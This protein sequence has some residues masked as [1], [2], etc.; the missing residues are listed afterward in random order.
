MPVIKEY[1]GKDI[2]RVC[3]GEPY[4][5]GDEDERNRY[6]PRMRG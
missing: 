4:R 6:S 1:D 3:G 2:P 5:G